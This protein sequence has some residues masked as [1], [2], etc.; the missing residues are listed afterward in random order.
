MGVRLVRTIALVA[1]LLAGAC[2]PSECER[3]GGH[4]V[5]YDCR[6]D[7][8][9]YWYINGEGNPAPMMMPVRRCRRACALPGDAA[10]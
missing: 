9:V 4:V 5:E 8:D 10:P 1:T 3:R 6:A 2:G 7:L